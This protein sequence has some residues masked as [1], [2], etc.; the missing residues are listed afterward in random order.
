MRH[1]DAK[2]MK[3]TKGDLASFCMNIPCCVLV[4]SFC[5]LASSSHAMRAQSHKMQR[6]NELHLCGAL[7][8]WIFA[9][10]VGFVLHMIFQALHGAAWRCML[11]PSLFPF[12][13]TVVPS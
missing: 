13:L 2:K 6:E 12:V 4:G 8:L 7:L 5:I 9:R 3:A 10:R 1:E 11:H